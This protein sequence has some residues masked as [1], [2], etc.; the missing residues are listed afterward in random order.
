MA[1]NNF[2]FF[3]DW[4]LIDIPISRMSSYMRGSRA[5]LAANEAWEVGQADTTPSFVS[6]FAKTMAVLSDPLIRA[7][8]RNAS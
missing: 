1:N 5:M 4:I 2:S 6:R 7:Y 3:L 8:H